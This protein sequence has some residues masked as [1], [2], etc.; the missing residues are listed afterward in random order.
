MREPAN[1]SEMAAVLVEVGKLLEAF[2]RGILNS[3]S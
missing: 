2:S 3:D 1:M